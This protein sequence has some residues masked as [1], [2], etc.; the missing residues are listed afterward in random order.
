MKLL[1]TISFY[2]IYL[3]CISQTSEQKIKIDE[4]K[5]A[6]KICKN[7]VKKLELL[8][9]YEAIVYEFDLE[10]NFELNN[11]IIA[12][13]DK[14]I[15]SNAKNIAYFQTTKS[16]A[17]NNMAI[18]M[19]MKGNIRGAVEKF[20]SA[21]L[22]DIAL[23]DKKS[24]A[25]SYNNLGTGYDYLG[26]YILA[27]EYYRKSLKLQLE[28]KNDRG[29]SDLYNNFGVIYNSLKQYDKSLKYYFL[30]LNIDR[31]LKDK[32][33]ESI[34]LNNIGSLYS[35]QKDYPKALEFS[36]NALAIQ[37][38][39][40]NKNGQA[41]TFGNLGSYY[42]D[43]KLIDSATYYLEQ[44]IAL[45][46][47]EGNKQSLGIFLPYYAQIKIQK[48]E[49]QSAL[50]IAQEAYNFGLE[51]GDLSSQSSSSFILYKVY[52]ILNKPSL[53]LKYYEIHTDLDKKI[54]ND[55][56]K[57]QLLSFEFDK[58][59]VE[60]SLKNNQKIKIKNTA[61]HF[62]EK[63]NKINQE[64]IIYLIFGLILLVLLILFVFNRFQVTK[65]QKLTIE[66]QKYEV[67]K[68]KMI[69]EEI[70][71]QIHDSINYAKMIQQA[72]LPILEVEKMFD[73]AF[74]IYQPKDIVSGDFYWLEQEN[75][76]SYFCVADCTGHGIPGA[77]IS[78]IGTILIN[79]IFNSKQIREP[80]LILNELSRL[81][82]LT[83]MTKEHK[84]LNDG[85][86]IS[87]CSLNLAKKELSFAG[88][89]NG[90][91]ILSSEDKLQVNQAPFLPKIEKNGVHLFK[92]EADK[93]PIGKHHSDE[94]E[95]SLKTIQ[96]QEDDLIVL[97]SDGFVDQFGGPKGKKFKSVQFEEILLN[98]FNEKISTIKEQLF[99]EFI[100]WK[101]AHEQVD[102]VC[103]IAVKV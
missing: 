43:L 25:A 64:K 61:L 63:Q 9:D 54:Q 76:V 70:N 37:L 55:E 23:N 53:A 91:Y 7:D 34:T 5:N 38:E 42:L 58:K 89:N 35:K 71:H 86:D 79:E 8:T 85:M 88:A 73:E 39:I 1:L 49:Y 32:Y 92:V 29:V 36:K 81:I 40:N 83:L 50:K 10:L 4:I 2:L 93:K 101:G 80:N 68:Q 84:I 26:D 96:V 15:K 47:S 74:L 11:Q 75:N 12:I 82:Q 98:L 27:I 48:K 24:I 57:K 19:Q 62:A 18:V 103:I 16:L 66:N 60:D 28:L 3:T 45:Y 95:F 46:R 41:M 77:F 56:N 97:L 44:S 102:D 94:S 14:N 72:V 100:T 17:L 51:T 52:K 22:L 65:K 78:M 87:F 30:S 67:E 31:K 21:L 90:I 13:C 20:H 6:I 33:S 99:T 59:S 69:I